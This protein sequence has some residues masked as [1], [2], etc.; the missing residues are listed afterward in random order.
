MRI[1]NTNI[2]QEHRI[3]LRLLIWLRVFAIGGQLV[4]VYFASNILNINLQTSFLYLW[5]GI[6]ALINI[7]T[8]LRT[9]SQLI[10]F[11]W[12]FFAHLLVDIFILTML[13]KYSDLV[14]SHHHYCL[15]WATCV[16]NQSHE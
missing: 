15:L 3:N 9:Y 8:F 7:L 16:G 11:R 1:I 14:T 4:A 10:I 6:Y 5:I 2:F 13:F 12:E